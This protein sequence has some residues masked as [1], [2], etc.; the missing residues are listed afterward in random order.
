[1]VVYEENF[2]PPSCRVL[3][4]HAA[5]NFFGRSITIAA[6][7]MPRSSQI[8]R[9]FTEINAFTGAFFACLHQ[10]VSYEYRNKSTQNKP[11]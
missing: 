10:T 8:Q 1:M 6:K 5:N 2:I 3:C 4:N 11:G 9:C 7:Y